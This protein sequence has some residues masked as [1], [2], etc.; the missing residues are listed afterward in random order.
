MIGTSGERLAAHFTV[1]GENIDVVRSRREA[2]LAGGAY[3][4]VGN[5]G[6]P[7]FVL[8]VSISSILQ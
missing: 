7:E 6:S 8:M 5:A 4:T 2:I 1:V 3:R